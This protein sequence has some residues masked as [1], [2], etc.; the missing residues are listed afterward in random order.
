MKRV[1]WMIT[2]MLSIIKVCQAQSINL[3]DSLIIH[4]DLAQVVEKQYVGK[5]YKLTIFAQ[6]HCGDGVYELTTNDGTTT[7]GR[8]HTLRGDAHDIN[9]T[10]LELIDFNAIVDHI[11]LLRTGKN[12]E[13]LNAQLERIKPRLQLNLV[14]SK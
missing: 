10:V 1:I 4:P 12:L 5:G 13:F 9:A 6:M 8:Q 3:L 11:Y 14:K 7:Y 2:I